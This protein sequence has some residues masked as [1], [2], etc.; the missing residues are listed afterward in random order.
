MHIHHFTK[1]NTAVVREEFLFYIF[2]F[3]F[4]LPTLLFRVVNVMGRAEREA[5]LKVFKSQ[6][7]VM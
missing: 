5:C 6:I 7:N 1:L 2:F 3:C 4:T